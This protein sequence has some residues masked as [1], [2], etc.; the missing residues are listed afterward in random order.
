MLSDP[1]LMHSREAVQKL[2]DLNG[3]FVIPRSEILTA[4]IIYGKKWG[5]VVFHIPVGFAFA[6]HREPRES[7]FFLGVLTLSSFSKRF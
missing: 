2:A 3:G 7:L 5:M 1:D 4:E 6:S